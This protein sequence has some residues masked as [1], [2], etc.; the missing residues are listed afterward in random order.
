MLINSTSAGFSIKFPFELRDI[1]RAAFPGAKWNSNEKACEVGPR[2]GNR[3]RQWASEIAE[4]EN[5][6]KEAEFIDLSVFEIKMLRL[7]IENLLKESR[8]RRAE[9]ETRVEAVILIK[10]SKEKLAA[11]KEAIA[12]VNVANQ[13]AKH[14]IIVS[15]NGVI[16]LDFAKEC[17]MGV[18]QSIDTTY[19][20]NPKKPYQGLHAGTPENSV[21]NLT[22]E[23]FGCWRYPAQFSR[24]FWLLKLAFRSLAWRQ[25][26]SAL[27]LRTC[28]KN[29]GFRL[30][31]PT[32]GEHP[33]WA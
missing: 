1:F 13:K 32:R 20:L 14:E 28:R 11:A 31:A 17:A 8:K 5:E 27:A 3:L 9:L 10:E 30:T 23:I 19:S 15:L 24:S 22:S 26:A 18:L 16:D 4:L 12:Q 25:A 2:S 29:L 21:N 33:C 7:E 6:L